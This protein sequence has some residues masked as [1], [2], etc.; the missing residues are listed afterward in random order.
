MSAHAKSSMQAQAHRVVQEQP[1]VIA[2]LGVAVGAAVA[3]LLPPSQIERDAMRPVSDAASDAAKAAAERV[4]G[5]VSATAEHLKNA[6]EQKGL[7]P[8]G[9]K[10][11]ARNATQTFSDT[12]AG[13]TEPQGGQPVSPRPGPLS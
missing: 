2:A 13:G 12:L 4:K 11:V 5:A 3:A 7:T 1:F 6:A 10:D 9:L 8:E